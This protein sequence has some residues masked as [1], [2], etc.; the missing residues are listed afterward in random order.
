MKPAWYYE[1]QATQA[2]A[3]AD[4]FRNRVPPETANIESRGAST[5]VYYRSLILTDGTDPL[6]FATQ[7]PNT[8]LANLTAAQAGL[9]TTLPSGDV[10]SR[11]RGSGVKPTK[12][13]WYS[14]AANP[15]RRRTAWGTSVAKYYDEQAGRSHYSIPFSK[16]TGAFTADDIRDAFLA[17]FGPGGS[18]RSLLGTANGRASITWE[19][20]TTSAQT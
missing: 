18:K 20:A 4:Y 19:S 7:V 6:I 11:L 8:T 5:D 15:T 12:V 3:R 13:H 9:L 1:K 14:G 2:Q 17:L 16:A 10:A